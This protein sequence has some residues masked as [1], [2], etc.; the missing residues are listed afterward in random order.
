MRQDDHEEEWIEDA[1]QAIGPVADTEF[2]RFKR[3]LRR[4]AG[5]DLTWWERVY[6]RVMRFIGFRVV[7]K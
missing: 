7:F 5:L 6:K 3:S 4:R 2:T 1:V